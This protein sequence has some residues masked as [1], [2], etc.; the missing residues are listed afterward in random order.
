[1]DIAKRVEFLREQLAEC[2]QKAAVAGT[3][4]NQT[5]WLGSS[6]P[7]RQKSRPATG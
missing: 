2:E 3:D 1:M 5:C 4:E 6:R 7:R